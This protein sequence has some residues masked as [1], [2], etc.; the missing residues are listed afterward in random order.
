M[1]QISQN[2][3][4]ILLAL[5]V[6]ALFFFRRRSR[7]HGGSVSHKG[8]RGD[9]GMLGR[10][11][12]GVAAGGHGGHHQHGGDCCGNCDHQ[13]TPKELATKQVAVAGAGE[14]DSAGLTHRHHGH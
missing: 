3:I 7:M 13:S 10:E 2:W 9:L 8:H 11:G 4:W 14:P 12:D 6:V 1:D 5:G